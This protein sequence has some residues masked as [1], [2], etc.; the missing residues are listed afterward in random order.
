MLDPLDLMLQ[1]LVV[2]M[3]GRVMS[4]DPVVTFKFFYFF[5][6]LPKI[7]PRPL[8]TQGKCPGPDHIPSLLY[9]KDTIMDT[10]VHQVKDMP[11]ASI[12][13]C[14]FQTP[15]ESVPAGTPGSPN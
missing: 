6:A 3:N 1:A 2:L 5:C 10:G 15:W 4:P 9:Y 11:R 13:A 14:E 12:E 7:E 8:C